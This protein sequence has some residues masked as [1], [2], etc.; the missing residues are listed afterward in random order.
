[1]GIA[2]SLN[3]SRNA[4]F[5][6]CSALLCSALLSRVLEHHMHLRVSECRRYGRT[7]KLADILDNIQR[8]YLC[9]N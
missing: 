2:A 7:S 5:L 1:S 4:S 9:Y 8:I 6:L 3:T